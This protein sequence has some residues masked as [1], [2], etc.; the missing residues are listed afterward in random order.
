MFKNQKKFIFLFLLFFTF[1]PFFSYAFM[2]VSPTNDV[3]SISVEENIVGGDSGIGNSDLDSDMEEGAF[4]DDFIFK[5]NGVEQIDNDSD[6]ELIKTKTGQVVPEKIKETMAGEDGREN[7]AQNK[8][9]PEEEKVQTEI[10][11]IKDEEN[12]TPE[13]L[14]MPQGV[15]EKSEDV[16]KEVKENI[17]RNKIVAIFD[18][19]DIRKEMS[20]ELGEKQEKNIDEAVRKAVEAYEENKKTRDFIDSIEEDNENKLDREIAN[21]IRNLK[22]EKA[23]ASC[24]KHY[25][26]KIDSRIAYYYNMRNVYEDRGNKLMIAFSLLKEGTDVHPMVQSAMSVMN[27]QIKDNAKNDKYLMEDIYRL[28]EE[29]EN[30]NIA[31]DDP[32]I[33]WYVKSKYRETAFY[34]SG[35]SLKIRNQG[36]LIHRMKMIINEF[37]NEKPFSDGFLLDLACLYNNSYVDSLPPEQYHYCD[38]KD[39]RFLK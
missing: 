31:T 38:Y 7:E 37:T 22:E 39:N 17:A 35:L 1:T 21:A 19:K 33:C 20:K 27:Y 14:R 32:D 6:I 3:E 25:L 15:K 12:I 28:R 36:I 8:I 9:L 23:L 26:S 2:T 4:V 24:K 34:V 5:E 16:K 18:V 11:E 13:L 30:T 10:L 29:L